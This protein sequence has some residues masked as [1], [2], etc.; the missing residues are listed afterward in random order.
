MLIML[1]LYLLIVLVTFGVLLALVVLEGGVL[2]P[3]WARHLPAAKPEGQ[4]YLNIAPASD[5]R[6]ATRAKEAMRLS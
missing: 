3:K 4:P 1:S 6:R 5:I 2:P